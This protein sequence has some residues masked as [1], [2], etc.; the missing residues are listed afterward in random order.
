MAYSLVL[1]T[2]V[3]PTTHLPNVKYDTPT[4]KGP[5]EGVVRGVLGVRP[6]GEGL[7]G[8]QPGGGPQR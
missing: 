4:P 7:S 8:C 1:A 6:V 2:S 5:G 3:T